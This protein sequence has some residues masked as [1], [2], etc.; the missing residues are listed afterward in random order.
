[1]GC[2]C[3]ECSRGDHGHEHHHKKAN[4][5]V[6]IIKI[7]VGALSVIL[8]HIFEDKEKIVLFISIFAYIVVAYDIFLEAFKEIKEGEIFSEYLLMIIATIGA[9]FIGEYHESVMVMLLFIVGELLQGIAV[10]KSRESIVKLVGLSKSIAH[11]KRDKEI[12]DIDP[13]ELKVGDIIVL[14][15]GE[16]LTVD[17]KV[18]KGSSYIDDSNLTG[19]S[20]PKFVKKGSELFAGIINTSNVLEIEVSKEYKDSKINKVLSLVEDASERKSKSDKIIR[21]IARV[22]TPCVIIAAICIVLI[23]W[24][25]SIGDLKE[26]IYTALTFL[27]ISCPCSII[28]SVPIT[29]FAA[30]GGASKKGVLIKGANFLDT[31]CRVK[32]I[33]FDKTGTISEGKFS[34]SEVKINENINEDEFIKLLLLAQYNSN[35]PIS[36]SIK[37]YFSKYQIDISEIKEV[38]EEVGKGMVILLQDD[39]K[40]IVGNKKLM[41]DYDVKCDFNDLG[42]VVYVAKDKQYLGYVLVEDKI[43]QTSYNAIKLLKKYKKIM[44]SG[45]SEEVCK[46]VSKELNI[47]E[48]HY[49]LLPEEKMKILENIIKDGQT[50]FVGDGINDTLSISLADVSVAMGIRGSDA[51]IE[52]SDI[53]IENDNLENISVAFDFAYKTR[54]LIIQNLIGIMAL[55][56]IFMILSIFGFVNMWLAI[57]SDVGLCIL[58]IINSMR[59]SKVKNNK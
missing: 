15:N 28:I 32:N 12:I 17:G 11:L 13:K 40:V 46:R 3:C 5:I 47:D 33:A 38:K 22:Y 30:I 36:I 55:K 23:S 34:V 53:V 20:L 48:Y 2:S 41:G 7:I 49:G 14:K 52:Y 16:L 51:T 35:H 4:Y 57:F 44:L 8:G 1:M 29:Y 50:M 58:S 21:K 18:I 27:L 31:L 56:I 45:D 25:F 6:L 26:S 59:A 37:D 24:L 43:K 39:S 9:F 10:D 19:E 54:K 42:T